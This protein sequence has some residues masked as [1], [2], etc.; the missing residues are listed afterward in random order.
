MVEK[1]ESESQT[2]SPSL[3]NKHDEPIGGKC[4]ENQAD[5]WATVVVDN[6]PRHPLDHHRE[7]SRRYV[8]E[9]SD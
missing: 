9:R 2:L 4:L 3:F 7:Y 5:M 6:R 8:R 1:Y